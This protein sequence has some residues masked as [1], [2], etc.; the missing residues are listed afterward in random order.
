[1]GTV[2]CTLL[3][4]CET[5]SE[6][7][8]RER[9]VLS[10]FLKVDNVGA[11]RL[12]SGWLFQANGPATKNTTVPSCSLVLG[13][14]KFHERK[15]TELELCA[16]ELVVGGGVGWSYDRWRRRAVY[17]SSAAAA[18]L[19]GRR[20]WRRR[21]Q[22][23]WEST[24]T[25]HL[26]TGVFFWFYR[27][28]P[29]HLWPPLGGWRRIV[30]CEYA[31]SARFHSRNEWILIVHCLISG[32]SYKCSVQCWQDAESAGVET[33][34]LENAALEN[35]GIKNMASVELIKQYSQVCCVAQFVIPEAE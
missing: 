8:T 12:C 20:R 15:Q 26:L 3:I 28:Q 24:E 17:F 11:E 23:G 22:T 33:A 29:L 35:V 14:T 5:V 18:W 19:Y 4:L 13:T 32:G 34:A 16:D 25:A 30:N 10:M 31:C 1:M 7:G 9:C 21:R 27:G 2:Q 6:V